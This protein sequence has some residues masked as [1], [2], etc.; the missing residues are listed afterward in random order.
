MLGIDRDIFEH[1]IPIHPMQEM[2]M[3]TTLPTKC[4]EAFIQSYRDMLGIDS[5]IVEHWI[6]TQPEGTNR[7]DRASIREWARQF[8]L[9]GRAAI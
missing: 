6:P 1:W 9:A 4:P 8:T 3:I 5:D 7:K 2:E